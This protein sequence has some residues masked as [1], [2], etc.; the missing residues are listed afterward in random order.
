MNEKPT[1][2]ELHLPTFVNSRTALVLRAYDKEG[3]ASLIDV[4]FSDI[5]KAGV[6]SGCSMLS[7]GD[8]R[9]GKSQLMMDIHRNYFGGSVD[10]GCKSN[11]IVA[12][13]NFVAESFYRTIDQDRIGEGKGMLSEARVPVDRRVT[14]LFTNI[15]EINLAIPE[16][17][18]EF[19]GVV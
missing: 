3:K 11:K 1:Y 6:L 12:R 9:C 16:V 5:P 15:E 14:A 7:I 10:N 19:F 18:V 13:N 4:L 8:T 2:E 17:Q